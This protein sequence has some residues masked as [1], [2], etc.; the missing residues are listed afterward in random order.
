M[1]ESADRLSL[2]GV[3][4]R[5]AVI[6]ANVEDGTITVAAGREALGKL[7]LENLTW[8]T[9]IENAR[10]SLRALHK[11]EVRTTSEADREFLGK[12]S[13]LPPEPMSPEPRSSDEPAPAPSDFAYSS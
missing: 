11:S 1:S 12:H 8:A 2:S 13:D 6:T 3:Y 10:K 5:V 4:S 7:L 9:A